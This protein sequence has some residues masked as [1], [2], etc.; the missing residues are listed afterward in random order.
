MIGEG[1]SGSGG[2]T[3]DSSGDNGNN[4]NGIST[5][6]GTDGMQ[7]TTSD[8]LALK[9]GLDFIVNT[10]IEEFNLFMDIAQRIAEVHQK[11]KE[12]S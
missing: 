6:T 3:T 2:V 1:S 11:V 7:A 12:I 9:T 10:V 5:S 4:I 8:I